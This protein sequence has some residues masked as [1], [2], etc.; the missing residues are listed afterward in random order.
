ME[1]G[2][3]EGERL[4]L[5]IEQKPKERWERVGVPSDKVEGGGGNVVWHV[6]PPVLVDATIPCPCQ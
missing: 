5:E 4:R 6:K 1:W 3:G 2:R